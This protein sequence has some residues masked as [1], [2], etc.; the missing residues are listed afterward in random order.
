MSFASCTRGLIEDILIMPETHIVT[1]SLI[2]HLALSLTLCL[3]LVE[4]VRMI[5]DE[6]RT[7]MLSALLAISQIESS[8]ARFYI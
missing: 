1:S 7:P 6:H 2:F 3:A 4:M 5:L 8:Y